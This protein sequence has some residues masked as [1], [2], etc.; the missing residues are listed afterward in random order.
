MVLVW[1][2]A[3]GSGERPL[4]PGPEFGDRLSL[5]AS[6]RGAAPRDVVAD[7]P[8]RKVDGVFVR[9]WR[10]RLPDGPAADS[11][12]ADVE[13]E[14]GAWQGE[15]VRLEPA[16]STTR[17]RV[18]LGVEAFEIEVSAAAHAQPAVVPPSPSVSP[19][20]SPTPTRPPPPPGTR[21]RLAILLDD[22][23]QS[24]ELLGAA[25]ALPPQVGISVLPFLPHSADVAAEMHR[26]G[27]EVWLHLP[28]EPENYPANNPGPGAVLVS[29]TED[30]IRSTVHMA[31]NNVPHSVGV[32]N[33][34]GSRATTSLR[35]MTWVMQEL[36]ARGVAFL[37]SR[38][39]INTVAEDA[40]RSQGVP[41]NRR[42][43]FLDNERTRSAIRAQLDEAIYRSRV[44][45]ELVAIGH[46][47]KVTIE[48]LEEELPEIKERGVKLVPP[49]KLTR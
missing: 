30:E 37:D 38:T 48:V 39:S 18:D 1:L 13:A 10:V 31:L 17:W 36:S 42:H 34:M 25:A 32:N 35:V 19:R 22:G 33:H 23:G 43:I 27:H 47:A 3:R 28:M 5:L 20:T 7:D 40:A 16:G 9:I 6:R 8:I 15:F 41:V 14:A 2:V 46:V 12:V 49:T 26:S 24:L 4:G 11:F 44:E 21:G 45:G 29:M